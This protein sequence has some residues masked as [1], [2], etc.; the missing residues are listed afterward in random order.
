MGGVGGAGGAG[1]GPVAQACDP[2]EVGIGVD[3]GGVLQCA[4]IDGAAQAAINASCAIHYGWRDNC[5]SPGCGSPPTKWGKVSEQD[6]AAN[7]G[8][9]TCQVSTLGA[10]ANLDIFGLEI[11]N[12][13]SNDRFYTGFSCAPGSKAPGACG[14]GLL[15]TGYD[16]TTPT[17]VTASGAILDYVRNSCT[18]VS[19]WVDSCNGCTNDP[20]EWGHSGSTACTTGALSTCAQHTLGSD[21]PQLLSFDVEGDLNSDD[22][23]YFGLRCQAAAPVSTVV[24]DACPADQFVTGIQA[25]GMLVCS[26]LA[27]AA[28]SYFR[29]HCAA[30]FGFSD[31]CGSCT[32]TPMRFGHVRDGSCAHN[33]QVD[34]TCSTF[35][36]AGQAVNLYGLSVE[37]SGDNN[38][39][40]YAA[41]RCE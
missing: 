27:P 20:V 1:G 5:D 14:A 37:G 13:D 25:D 21:M 2:L 28:M 34:D 6:C 35:M 9:T 17:C 8:N 33:G 31:N 30:H 38:D 23:F 11:D 7:G 4:P 22:K 19:G 12:G 3:V 10:F 24:A 39:K 40:F 36:V 32:N 29:A 15:L 41:F 18:L 16:G 26:S